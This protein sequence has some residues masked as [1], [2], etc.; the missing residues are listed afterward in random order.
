VLNI[1]G[2]AHKYQVDPLLEKCNIVLE[3]WLDDCYKEAGAGYDLKQLS[4]LINCFKIFKI[5]LLYDFT[6]LCTNCEATI[7]KFPSMYYCGTTDSFLNTVES[8]CRN[9]FGSSLG[10]N[11]KKF[12]AEGEY[13]AFCQQRMDCVEQFMSLSHE[14]QKHI[15]FKRVCLFDDQTRK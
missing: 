11:A 10:F 15:L 1:T 3:D 14:I 9:G 8:K 6:E 2:L 13:D 4:Y 5:A 7:S 12:N